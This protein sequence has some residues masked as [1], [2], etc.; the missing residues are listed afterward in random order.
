MTLDII[1]RT[2]IRRI[3]PRAQAE[4]DWFAHQP[5]LQ[6]AISNAA[7]AV[8]SRGNRYSHQRRLRKVALERALDVLSKEAGAIERAHDFDEL[9]A[10]IDPALEPIPGLGELY[11]YDTSLR[12][13]AKLN[14]F[15]DKVYLHAG[16]R[17]GARALGLRAA[18]TLDVSQLPKE[19]R[20]LRPHE[21]EDV[22]CIF[23]D[24]LTA[25]RASPVPQDIV[26]RSWC[27]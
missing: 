3:R 7:R 27:G 4:I 19:F 5:S 2:Y 24:E 26:H 22:L 21:I 23:K 17:L 15:P 6:A 11:V 14:L 13:G 16:T 9:F 8:N 18:A 10:L 12:I 25:L 1:V 20:S